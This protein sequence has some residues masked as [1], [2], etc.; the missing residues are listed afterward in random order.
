MI[1]NQIYVLVAQI[2]YH[3]DDSLEAVHTPKSQQFFLYSLENDHLIKQK[4]LTE[5]ADKEL[6]SFGCVWKNRLFFY[7][8]EPFPM[9]RILEVEVLQ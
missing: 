8:Q 1:N 9:I 7:R 2:E 5:I 3:G 6:V 4:E